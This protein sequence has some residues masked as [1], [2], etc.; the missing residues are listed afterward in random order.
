MEPHLSAPTASSAYRLREFGV[1]ELEGEG[2]LLQ[3]GGKPL[4][5]L[6]WLAHA[7]PRRYSRDEL[8]ELFWPDDAPPNARKSLRQALSV[9]RR[10]LGTDA[11]GA[12]GDL[13]W[14][15]DGV[16]MLE[17]RQLREA[18]RARTWERA[19]SLYRGPFALSLESVGGAA[20]ER[21][22]LGERASIANEFVALAVHTVATAR[23]AGDLAA[24]V[25]GA[26]SAYEVAG[27]HDA[28]VTAYVESLVAVGERARADAV[29]RAFR[30]EVDGDGLGDRSREIATVQRL[31]RLLA[32]AAPPPDTKPGRYLGERLVAREEMIGMIHRALTQAR[33]GEPQRLLV[34]GPGGFGK[35]RLL[36]EVDA[37]FRAYS[38]RIV[39]LTFTADMREVRGAALTTIV[40]AL[41]RLGG[42]AGVS[43]DSA[44]A[45]VQVAP[46]LLPLYGSVSSLPAEP[47]PP[48]MVRAVRELLQ[49]VAEE[50]D[51]VLLLDDVQQADAWSWHVWQQTTVEAPACLLEVATSRSVERAGAHLV[52]PLPPFDDVAIRTLLTSVAPVDDGLTALLPQLRQ[53]SQGAPG[54]LL[55]M[56]RTL[57]TRGYLVPRAE[58]WWT[59]DPH[60]L[61]SRID[62]AWVDS[63]W[64]DGAWGTGAW[65]A[66]GQ[67]PQALAL[68]LLD[69][70]RLWGR[71]L[72]EA[73]LLGAVRVCRPHHTDGECRD[74]L[75]QLEHEGH[76]TAHGGEW[77]GG[78]LLPSGRHEPAVLLDAMVRDRFRDG[79]PP[80][81]V[82]DRLARLAGA[83]GA[84]VVLT[85]LM[86]RLS[87][88]RSMRR[89]GLQGPALAHHLALV[90]GRPEWERAL[91]R[92]L[93]FL[94]RRSRRTLVALGA[95]AAS[96]L[97]ATGALVALW[98]PRLVVESRPMAMTSVDGVAGLVVQPRVAVYDGF[99]RRRPELDVSVRV[100]GERTR[101]IGD[102]VQ[103]LRD[104][105]VQFERLALMP[106]TRAA[107][108]D[109]ARPPVLTFAGPWWVRG[110]RA[111][112]AGAWWDDER[113]RFRVVRAVAN[114][115]PVRADHV[116]PLS[117]RDDSL[118]LTLTFEFT[119]DN[120]TANYVV[121]A[122][123][124]WL[125]HDSSVVRV[126]GL[127]RPV[128]N[129]WQTVRIAVP[130]PRRAGRYHL[131][132]AM[133]TEDS[134]DHL[135]S[136]TNWAVGAPIWNDGN[137]LQDLTPAQRRFLRDSGWV[138]QPGA[139][140]GRYRRP[141][142]ALAI[143]DSAWRVGVGVGEHAISGQLVVQG[144]VF[145]LV[146]AG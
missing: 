141:E 76:L 30:Q 109:D 119:T 12:E 135:F 107:R 6:L 70:L 123:P 49:A 28:V 84:Q 143:G 7:T 18:V 35:S 113:D 132:M 97:V 95:C 25:T 21:W 50:R 15:H 60:V 55:R 80:M 38:L 90:A 69:L 134:V 34:T 144:T 91:V 61:P 117:T 39:R 67:P 47:S 4:A 79:E 40:R 65:G 104:G 86:H 92:A 126:A 32:H 100:S 75:R 13:V 74:A 37:R 53:A 11:L 58:G 108:G 72:P 36:D 23:D 27:R 51:T 22:V 26:A 59:S 129:A 112:V 128:V 87:R 48:A 8:C 31:D 102:T 52:M 106:A 140:T 62:S 121:G 85:D 56:L 45:L 89:F 139:L 136:A 78:E 64:V 145:E 77:V 125:P 66:G 103:R 1:P 114:G 73:H 83:H 98:Q 41:A 124:D 33:R 116:I 68:L 96:L 57:E 133:G 127:P 101:V 17:S 44:A 5:L 24:A 138:A 146:V 19:R 81:P 130:A 54:T 43:G 110:T 14:L 9:I 142:G 131:I 137:D 71:P 99:G 42:A 94:G 93:G 105:R 88:A 82:I 63:A 122:G 118:H 2:R 10:W 46:D 29:L 120:A 115:R 111:D 20:F 3:R 16:M